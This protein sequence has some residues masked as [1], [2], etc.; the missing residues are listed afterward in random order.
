[1]SERPEFIAIDHDDYHAKHVGRLPDGRQFFLTTPFEPAG[2]D[3]SGGEYVALYV[4][5]ATGNLL[6]AKI[7]GFGSRA[8]MNDEARR[9]KHQDRLAELGDLSFERIEVKPFSVER[10]GLQFGLIVRDPEDEH[11]VFAVELL[12]GNYMAFFEPWNSG[13]YDT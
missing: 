11:D 7:D 1:M 6:E 8:T 4:F 10:F 3:R 13:E 2:R 12:P 5:D 9:K